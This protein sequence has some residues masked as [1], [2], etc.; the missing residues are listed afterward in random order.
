M[1]KVLLLFMAVCLLIFGCKKE[2]GVYN[3]DKKIKK[4]LQ[5]NDKRLQEEWTWNK[6]LLQ[7]IDYYFGEDEVYYTEIF[8]YDSKNRIIR[9]EDPEW[10]DYSTISYNNDGYDKISYYDE[11][12]LLMTA[13]FKYE[14][15]KISRIDITVYDFWGF[16]KTIKKD[17]FITKIIPKEIFINA[18][19]CINRSGAKS[20]FTFTTNLK[21]NGDN[22]SETEMVL[23][24]I[25]IKSISENYDKKLNPFYS[26]LNGF[27]DIGEGGVSGFGGYSKNNVGKVTS[28]YMNE[29]EVVEYTYTYEGKFPS[30][31]QTQYSYERRINIT[32]FEYCPVPK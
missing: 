29:E 1:K 9:I 19:E 10:G 20:E 13:A 31:I 11:E 30:S 8:K 17:G 21:Y 2:E 23:G 26:S 6:D 27:L 25:T 7:K 15:K 16:D 32:Y 4:I 5:G 3:P 24:P 22:V 12:E 14:K 18:S 28:K